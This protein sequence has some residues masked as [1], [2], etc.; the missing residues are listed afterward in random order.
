V[1]TPGGQIRPTGPTPP[2]IR[3]GSGRGSGR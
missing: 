3:S 1:G 2:P